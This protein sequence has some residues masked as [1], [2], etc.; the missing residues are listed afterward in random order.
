[1][2]FKVFLVVLLRGIFKRPAHRKVRAKKAENSQ[3]LME[4]RKRAF[5][6]EE[7]QNESYEMRMKFY[8]DHVRYLRELVKV[9]RSNLT[10]VKYR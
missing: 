9:W 7:L 10:D 3:F 2:V 1:M 5:G 6:P 8:A 4:I